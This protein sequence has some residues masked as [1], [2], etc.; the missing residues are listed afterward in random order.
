MSEKSVDK[1]FGARTLTDEEVKLT[2]PTYE[3]LLAQIEEFRKAGWN[4]EQS[5][6]LQNQKI[7]NIS[8]IGARGTGKTS[9]L[10]TLISGLEKM[11][12]SRETCPKKGKN[13]LG[14]NIM[15]PLIVPET[16]SE[17]AS[18]MSMI[19]G[20]FKQVVDK[21]EKEENRDR[22]NN[23]WEK[24]ESE[25]V[26]RYKELVKKF[27]LI[28]PDYKQISVKEYTTENDYV[29]KS[30]E[31]YQA[32]CEFLSCFHA[33]I[34][35]MLKRDKDS[36]Q[37]KLIFIFIDDIDLCS[38]RSV[39]IVRTLLA[40]LSHP[41]IVTVIS[42]DMETFEEALVLDFI[43]ADGIPNPRNLKETF[44][45]SHATAGNEFLSR[46]KGLLMNT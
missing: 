28:Q 39:E 44:V 10:K 35:A 46:K 17:G 20:L 32:D 41:R 15:L 26:K 31:I 5:S 27:C 21:I 11:N 43:R 13:G 16:M 40:Y 37:E 14:I 24:E 4:E 23:C 45:L 9:I 33:F 42:G 18:M 34:H 22:G 29:R 3:K 1:Q 6:Q 36:M 19:L 25:V 2:L 30:S 12:S 8:I 38:H 7:N